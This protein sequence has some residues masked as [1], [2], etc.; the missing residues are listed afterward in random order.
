MLEARLAA[1]ERRETPRFTLVRN[2]MPNT[3]RKPRRLV[4]NPDGPAA[5]NRT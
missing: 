1:H 5:K 4:V 3:Q 2:A